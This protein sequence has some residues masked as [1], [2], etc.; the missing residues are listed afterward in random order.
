MQGFGVESKTSR[1]S[2]STPC[3]KTLKLCTSQAMK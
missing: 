2:S 1:I 3:D